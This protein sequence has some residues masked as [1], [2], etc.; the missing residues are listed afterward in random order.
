MADRLR[1][2]G[3]AFLTQP[4]PDWL[5][6]APFADVLVD[7]EEMAEWVRSR[8]R[9]PVAVSGRLLAQPEG[10]YLPTPS[11]GLEELAFPS[12]PGPLPPRG[13]REAGGRAIDL[14]CGAGRDAFWLQQHGWQVLGVDRLP[15][16]AEIPFV[17]ANLHEFRTEERFNLVLLHYCWDPEYLK[18][19]SS[20]CKAGGMVSILA[21]SELSWRCFGHPRKTKTLTTGHIGLICPIEFEISFEEEFWSLDRHSVRVVL[22]RRR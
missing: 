2:D 4:V 15:P 21:H 8:G 7:C 9:R 11:P 22:E 18:L 1:S 20:L 6:L 3:P 16:Q 10:E 17:Q 19:A 14:G 5:L 12:P 13:A